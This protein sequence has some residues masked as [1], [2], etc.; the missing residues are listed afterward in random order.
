MF[1]VISILAHPSIFIE[2]YCLVEWVEEEGSV[3]VL[4]ETCVHG[5][6]EV[7]CVCQVRYVRKVYPGKILAIG[8]PLKKDDFSK[9][10][11]HHTNFTGSLNE[12]KSEEQKYLSE[13]EDQETTDSSELLSSSTS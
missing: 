12:V 3:S 8:E 5:E 4:P 13:L 6:A 11:T 1:S 7:G 10:G 2:K 9:T